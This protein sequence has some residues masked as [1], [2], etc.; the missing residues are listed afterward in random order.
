MNR[1]LRMILAAAAVS[2][3]AVGGAVT[4]TSPAQAVGACPA[5]NICFYDTA[6][7]ASYMERRDG[8]DF[9]PGVCIPMPSADN[10]RTGYITNR[11]S[12]AWRVY[13]AG[14][15]SG[16]PGVIY[17]NSTGSM[18]ATWNNKISSYRNF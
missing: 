6:V 3:F 11:A 8:D 18:D 2:L 17:A 5:N 12:H 15:C 10:N 9:S 1:I 7:S 4:A 13:D 14:N 16:T